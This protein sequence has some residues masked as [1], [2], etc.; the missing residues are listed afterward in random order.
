MP[1][2]SAQQTIGPF[3]HVLEEDDWADLTRFGADGPKLILRGRI[4]D[5]AGA[6]VTDACVEIWQTSPAPAEDFPGWGRCATDGNGHYQMVTFLPGQ[7][8]HVS[9][10]I[11][12]RG[13]LKPLMTRAYFEHHPMLEHDAVLRAV[14][15]ARRAT[16]MAKPPPPL[17]EVWGGGENPDPGGEDVLQFDI[18][19]QGENETVFFEI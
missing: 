8:A 12:A 7:A 1:G 11:H 13:L 18:R 10:M 19:L 17:G 6:P 14:D 9:V 15:P 3:W 4:T 2:A 5:G 16:L